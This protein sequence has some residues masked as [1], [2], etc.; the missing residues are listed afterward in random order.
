MR[1]KSRSTPWAFNCYSQ[2]AS[3]SAT[4]RALWNRAAGSLACNFSTTRRPVRRRRVF[5]VEV[6]AGEVAAALRA[7]LAAGGLD[8][9]AAHRL[10]GGREE[11][12]PVVPPPLVGGSD[13]PEV[14]LVD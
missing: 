5:G 11:V 10:G 9:D 1:E 14:G 12:P 8:E 7:A 6:V 3:R 2:S 13:E 4:S